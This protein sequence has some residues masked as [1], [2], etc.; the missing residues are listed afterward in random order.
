MRNNIARLRKAK[1]LTQTELAD[2]IGTKI[3][4]L[5]K[6]ERASRKLDTVWLTKIAKA[7]E[8]DE[9]ELIGDD[10]LVPLASAD[11]LSAML[12]VFFERAAPGR[13]PSDDLLAEVGS[14]LRGTLQSLPDVPAAVNDPR[15]ARTLAAGR[16][17]RPAPQE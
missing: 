12:K 9:R 6:L 13:I 10:T 2:L 15:H 4:M 5:G 11:S 3:S 8:C 7:L 1:G 14:A 17:A 16:A